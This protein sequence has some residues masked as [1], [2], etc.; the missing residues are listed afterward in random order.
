MSDMELGP[1]YEYESQPKE[2]YLAKNKYFNIKTSILKASAKAEAK[3]N[4]FEEGKLNPN[5]RL[6]IEEEMKMEFYPIN[7]Q[8]LGTRLM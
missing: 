5:L 8:E 3:G 4:I 2:A 1:K 7:K 6:G